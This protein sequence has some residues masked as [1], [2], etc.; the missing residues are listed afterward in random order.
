MVVAGLHDVGE[1][2][3]EVHGGFLGGVEVTGFDGLAEDP[4]GA[5]RGAGGGGFFVEGGG[6]GGFA[7]GEGEFGGDF[8]T[9]EGFFEAWGGGERGGGGGRANF[10]FLGKI[11]LFRNQRAE[12]TDVG[13]GSEFQ[14]V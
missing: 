4:C 1:E 14:A 11:I 7:G 5:F 12:Q 2:F 8:L 13:A 10:L 3:T 9:G 6:F